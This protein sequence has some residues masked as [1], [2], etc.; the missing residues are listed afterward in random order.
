MKSQMHACASSMSFSRLY[1][2]GSITF[3]AYAFVTVEVPAAFLRIGA[4]KHF[5]LKPQTKRVRAL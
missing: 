4:L 3:L 2:S 5:N 1:F